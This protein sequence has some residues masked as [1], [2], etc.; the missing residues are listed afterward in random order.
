MWTMVFFKVLPVPLQD[1]DSD[2]ID[3][4]FDFANT[5]TVESILEGCLDQK[6]EDKKKISKDDLAELGY[7]DEDILNMKN[8]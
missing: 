3:F 4:I 6:E 5:Y 7:T 2:L 1:L 8:L